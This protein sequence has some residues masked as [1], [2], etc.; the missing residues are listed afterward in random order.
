MLHRNQTER[1]NHEAVEKP[2]KKQLKKSANKANGDQTKYAISKEPKPGK[3]LVML[4]PEIPMLK[5]K[6]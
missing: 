2:A 3:T 4:P 1:N 5:P 6:K